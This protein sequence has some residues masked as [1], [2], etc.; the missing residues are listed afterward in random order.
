VPG[1]PRVDW[2]GQTSPKG[3]KNSHI[4]DKLKSHTYFLLFQKPLIAFLNV[5]QKQKDPNY[6]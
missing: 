1:D 4:K 5:F 6:R 3:G 2:F